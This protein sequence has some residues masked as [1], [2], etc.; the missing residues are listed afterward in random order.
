M[1]FILLNTKTETEA[2]TAIQHIS[3]RFKNEMKQSVVLISFLEAKK[4]S[5]LYQ[6]TVS[7]NERKK[8]SVTIANQKEFRKL[9]KSLTKIKYFN[10]PTSNNDFGK[11]DHGYL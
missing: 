6:L 11:T 4:H 2:E 10:C 8:Y 9:V 5:S 3:N 1:I 7:W